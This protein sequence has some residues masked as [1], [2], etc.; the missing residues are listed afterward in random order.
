[1]SLRL[2]RIILLRAAKLF[3]LCV[4]GT[5]F[6]AAFAIT[7]SSLT[8][9][10]LA[11]VLLLRIKR[12]N[13]ILFGAYL[14][15]CSA[16]FSS[17]GFYLS[18]RLSHWTR[19]PREILTASTLITGIILLLRWPLQL[20]FATNEFLLVFWVLT[21]A[22][23]VVARMVGQ[24]LLSYI[25][26]RGKNLRSIVIVGEGFDASALA[27]RIEKEPTLGYR[28]VQIIDARES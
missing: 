9:P 1:M 28:V 15:L 3:D 18:H 20:N 8:W 27:E 6:I 10:T 14:V 13:I 2:R 11:E 19:R 5:T 17:R 23:F 22:I 4:V 21:F 25:R 16:L 26:T 24:R 7:S 12:L